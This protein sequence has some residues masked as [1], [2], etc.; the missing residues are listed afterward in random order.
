MDRQEAWDRI[1]LLL[2]EAML[3][4]AHWPAAFGL[5]DEACGMKGNALV[6]GR[7]RSQEDCRIFLARF[8]QRGVRDSDRESWYFENYYPR[9]ERV[10]RVAQL[11][12]GKL[13]GMTELYTE[14]ERKTSAAYIEA[15]P[16]GGYQ[17]GLNVR[18]DGPDGTSIVWV[19]ADSI[20][21]GGWGV[22]QI[23][24]IENL[25]PHI[26]RYVR[27]RGALT[28]AEALGSS[29]TDMLEN[30]RIGVIHLGRDAN[31]VAAN[32]RARDILRLGEGLLDAGGQLSAWLPPENARLKQMLAAALRPSGGKPVGGSMT[33][34]RR[35]LLPRLTVH[36]NPVTAREWDFGRWDTAALVLVVE[37]EN[38]AKFDVVV[39]NQINRAH[40]SAMLDLTPAETQV[41]AL[42]AEGETVRSIAAATERKESSIRWHLGRIF[43]KNDISRQ[44][45]LVRLVLSLTEL[46]A[47][48]R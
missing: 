45:E 47:D 40:V 32:D 36:V 21:R 27:V 46:Q 19:L 25:L 33:I 2:N 17:H 29:L 24:L 41:A 35:P 13:V 7:G 18:L 14:E 30:T 1:V 34:R 10:P 39:E 38:H 9:D 5:I 23:G 15:L 43:K 22:S 28:R 48:R 12:D 3:D 4:D 26:R 8:C 11:P 37:Q 6:V 16:R 31:I 42:L 20:E 44:S